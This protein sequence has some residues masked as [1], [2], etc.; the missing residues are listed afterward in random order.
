LKIHYT[1][2]DWCNAYRDVRNFFKKKALN[3]SRAQDIWSLGKCVS[4]S[5]KKLKWD[6]I[7]WFLKD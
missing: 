2:G 3:I 1:K 4:I 7:T 5:W 6:I